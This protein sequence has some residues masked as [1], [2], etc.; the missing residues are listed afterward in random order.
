M[1]NNHV[2]EL[3]INT[4]VVDYSL[5]TWIKSR[6]MFMKKVGPFVINTRTKEIRTI[7][8]V[9]DELR[10]ADLSYNYFAVAR[11]NINSSLLLREFFYTFIESKA[12]WAT[13]QRFGFEFEDDKISEETLWIPNMERALMEFKAKKEEYLADKSIPFESV[14]DKMPLGYSVNWQ[15]MMPIKQFMIYL[16]AFARLFGIT[17]K[18]WETV[19]TACYKNKDLRPWLNLIPKYMYTPEVSS[20]FTHTSKTTEIGYS[21]YSQ[22]IRHEGVKVIGFFDFL[23]S[24]QESNDESLLPIRERTFEVSISADPERI[25]QIVRIR[26]DWFAMTDNWNDKNS[27]GRI[28]SLYLVDEPH[29]FRNKEF[30]SCFDKDANFL[31]NSFGT[32]GLDDN[33]RI[34][35]GYKTNL[36]NPFILESHAIVEERIKRSGMNPLY[37]IYLQLFDDGYVKDNPNNELRKKWE[38]LQNE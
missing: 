11:F 17:S 32:H 30:L 35:K 7:K 29:L 18:I 34:A 25:N 15:C 38:E 16:S 4:Q 23:K 21:L 26:T 31:P 10:S 36:P 2:A 14:R 3:E 1:K 27:W 28:L 19:Y 33:L 9:T 8:S 37:K 22:L 12:N 20:Y 5:D 24:L 6:R 13:T